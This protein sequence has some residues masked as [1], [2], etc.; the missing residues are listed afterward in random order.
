MLQLLEFEFFFL[1]IESTCNCDGSFMVNA[2]I[3]L[4]KAKSIRLK[5][6][7]KI[8]QDFSILIDQVFSYSQL[9]H[10]KG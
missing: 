6:K 3:V 9:P 1:K 8:D 2:F 5:K 4:S 7:R 10:L